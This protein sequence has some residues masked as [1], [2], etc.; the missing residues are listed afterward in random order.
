VAEEMR[1]AESVSALVDL[2]SRESDVRGP[3]KQTVR[4]LEAVTAG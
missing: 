2:I 3:R 4:H 1:C